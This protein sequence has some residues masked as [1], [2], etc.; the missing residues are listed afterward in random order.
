MP[1][2]RGNERSLEERAEAI[3]A[4]QAPPDDPAYHLRD[5]F[6]VPPGTIP[7]SQKRFGRTEPPGKGIPPLTPPDVP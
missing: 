6:L 1:D 4:R 7:E 2:E 5:W 3:W